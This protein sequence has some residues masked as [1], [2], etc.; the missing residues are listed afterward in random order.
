MMTA[1]L[2]TA[3]ALGLRFL[4]D[5]DHPG[6]ALG[7]EMGEAAHQTARACIVGRAWAIA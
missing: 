1:P 7:I 5:I 6:I 4:G 3:I 2:A